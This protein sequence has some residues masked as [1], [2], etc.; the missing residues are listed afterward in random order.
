MQ[1]GL[2]TP[3]FTFGSGSL[4]VRLWV[5]WVPFRAHYAVPCRP[6]GDTE[7]TTGPVE[8]SPVA[9]D[10]DGGGGHSSAA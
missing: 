10:T 8:P 2:L 4:L 9:A 7:R 3:I 6:V 1:Y 5:R